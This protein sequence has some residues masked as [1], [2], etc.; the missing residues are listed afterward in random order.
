[1]N[2]FLKLIPFMSKVGAHFNPQP[3]ASEIE[4][5]QHKS[6]LDSIVESCGFSIQTIA[7]DGNCCFGAIAYSLFEQKNSIEVDF[8]SYLSSNNLSQDYSQEDLTRVL[9]DM[10]VQEWL[11]HAQDY[12]GFLS[13]STVEEEAPTFLSDGYYYGEL[14]NAMLLA[15]SNALE[16][17]IIVFSSAL[18]HHFVYM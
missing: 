18:H 15:I 2:H 5:A 3:S 11:T 10:A 16:I 6:R 13:D 17:P 7:V 4:C 12:Q 9:R 1:M 14:A 8:P